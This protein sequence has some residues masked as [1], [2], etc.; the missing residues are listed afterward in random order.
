MSGS[1]SHILSMGNESLMNSR[2]AVDVTGHNI[3]NANV[4]GYSRQ[5]AKIGPRD[6]VRVGNH[7]FGQGATLESVDRVHDKFLES[8]LKK[9]LQSTTAKETIKSGIQRLENLFNPDLTSTVRDRMNSFFNSL[10]ELAN[11][12]EEPAVRTHVAEVAN[13]LALT[14]NENHANIETIQLDINDQITSEVELLN[15]RLQ[16]LAHVNQR[17][18]ET[19]NGGESAGDLLDQRDKLVR[20][21]TSTIDATSYE[22]S[23]GMMV[24][25]GPGGAL[26]LEGPNY[27]QF[28][29]DKSTDQ[30]STKISFRDMA[31][32]ST[33]VTSKVRSGKLGALIELR[34]GH[35][36]EIRD[37]LNQLA[38]GFADTINSVHRL[39][40]GGRGYDQNVGR[41]FF[42]GV[43][44]E[45]GEPARN[46][47]VA[48][49]IMADPFSIAAAMTPESAGD[50]AVL[51]EMIKLQNTNTMEGG[52]TTFAGVYDKLVGRLGNEMMRSTE[53]LN[54]A[55]VVLA[56]I[57]TQK[58]AISGVSLDEE[59]SNLIKYQHLFAASSRIITTAD[60]LM[61][62][63]LDLKR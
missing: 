26:L 8:Q 4:E 47:R 56:Q 27:G 37:N 16:E 29:V 41:D 36:Q 62:T 9:E 63:I 18:L 6:P 48:S 28:T 57:K 20:E 35:A 58:E 49:N 61:K 46:I 45:D 55:Q 40:Y 38:Q 34:D 1:L 12:P 43:N 30:R 32:S 5:F 7:T 19:S 53:E 59:A 3:S 33:D 42:E 11:Y 2:V 23:R 51:I 52:K 13:N 22:G 10:R 24:M 39:G 14:I 31:N 54:A 50:N 17:V 44:P 15:K 60:E 21:I 25:R